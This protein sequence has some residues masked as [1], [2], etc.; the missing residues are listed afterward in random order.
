MAALNDAKIIFDK[1]SGF[2]FGQAVTTN[3][4]FEWFF[5]NHNDNQLINQDTV[6]YNNN[7][8]INEKNRAS[9]EKDSDI[10]DKDINIEHANIRFEILS[11]EEKFV[12]SA[13]SLTDLSP[14]DACY[15][16]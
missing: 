11:S 2:V 15:N 8:N 3:A 16:I 5:D 1:K 12:N 14:L 10:G 9:K 6:D 4:V 7:M 13:L